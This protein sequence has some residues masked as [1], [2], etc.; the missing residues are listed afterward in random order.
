[1]G[2]HLPLLIQSYKIH[3]DKINDKKFQA[4]SIFSWEMIFK[5]VEFHFFS[6]SLSFQVSVQW[7]FAIPSQIQSICESASFVSTKE[8]VVVGITKRKFNLIHIAW[9]GRGRNT[10]KKCNMKKATKQLRRRECR[11]RCCQLWTIHEFAS[12]QKWNKVDDF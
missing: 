9:R 7:Y 5:I 2:T 12:E 11:K 1:M 6:V 4:I 3:T 8:M 10:N